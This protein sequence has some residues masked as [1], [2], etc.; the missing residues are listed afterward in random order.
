MSSSYVGLLNL[1][2]NVWR[3]PINLHPLFRFNVVVKKVTPINFLMNLALHAECWMF[4]FHLNMRN[5]FK[6]SSLG[7]GQ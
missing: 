4:G 3:L 6:L 1:W 2:A 5:N 7:L